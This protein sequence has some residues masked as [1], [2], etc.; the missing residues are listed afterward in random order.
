MALSGPKEH[1][2]PIIWKSKSEFRRTSIVS[3]LTGLV[4]AFIGDWSGAGGY[5]NL[6]VSYYEG[7]L[8]WLII[9]QY[10]GLA[11][12]VA[13]AVILIINHLREE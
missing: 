5:N 1:L 3:I 10:L 11:L 2:M 8:Y 7:G 4:I 12:I 9:V 6:A 13:G